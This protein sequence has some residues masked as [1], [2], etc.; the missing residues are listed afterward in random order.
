[1]FNTFLGGN[2]AMLFILIACAAFSEWICFALNVSSPSYLC[3]W[4]HLIFPLWHFWNSWKLLQSLHFWL[5][6]Y[7]TYKRFASSATERLKIL[8]KQ[9]GLLN[10]YGK[11]LASEDYS[12]AL[13]LLYS[14]LQILKCAMITCVNSFYLITNNFCEYKSDKI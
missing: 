6:P 13:E 2:V 12:S 1:M 8:I 9:Q 4:I 3:Y 7:A 14:K 5:V 11:K 10:I